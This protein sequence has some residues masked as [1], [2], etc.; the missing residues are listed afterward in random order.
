[1]LP[2]CNPT[3]ASRNRR[4]THY[5]ICTA[6]DI[7]APQKSVFPYISTV[8]HGETERVFGADWTGARV[9]DRLVA[10]FRLSPGL[11]VYSPRKGVFVAASE[12]GPIDGLLLIERTGRA[13]DRDRCDR[14]LAWA[15]ASAGGMSTRQWCQLM[16]YSRDRLYRSSDDVAVWLNARSDVQQC[17]HDLT[18]ATLLG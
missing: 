5:T 2:I 4:A 15:K 6:A 3:G 14:L 10:A 1:M 17:C 11:A 8:W 18:T 12:E 13:L 16:R 7:F 9:R